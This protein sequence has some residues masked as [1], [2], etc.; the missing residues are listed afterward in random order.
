M[1]LYSVLFLQIFYLF[2]NC[3][4]IDRS[5]ALSSYQQDI[6]RCMFHL[7]ELHHLCLVTVIF[8]YQSTDSIGNHHRLTFQENAI[9]C[10]W[11]NDFRL[12]HLLT[13]LLVTTWSA[14]NQFSPGFYT[15]YNSVVGGSVAG[16]KSDKD[17]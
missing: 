9:S 11:V 13:N 14:D 7:N 12:L 2:Q 5:I 6:L 1:S 15:F 3:I 4:L 8:H 16:M 17:I 10:D